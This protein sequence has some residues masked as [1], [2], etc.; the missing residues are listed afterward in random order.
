MAVRPVS[1]VSDKATVSGSFGT[2]TGTVTFTFFTASSTCTGTS[3][4]SGTVT[5]DA[6]G[7]AHPSASQGPLSAGSYS[8]IAHYN[9]DPNYTATASLCTPLALTARTPSS[10]TEIHNASHTVVTSWPAGPTLHDTA[11]LAGAFGTPPAPRT[12]ALFTASSTCTGT[13]VG[14]GTVTLDASGVAHPSASQGPLSAGSYS[15]IAHYNGDPNYTEIGRASCRERVTALA[16]T[17]PNKIH[18]ARPK[19]EVAV[20]AGTTVHYLSTMRR[21]TRSLCDWSSDVCSSDLSTCTGTSVASGTVTLDASGVAHPS[22][23]QG[24]LSAGSYSFIAHYNG[25]PNYT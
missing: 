7:V 11:T 18:K 8:F 4:G 19:A 1:M 22:A 12:S 15:F 14:S 25:D 3:V 6:S 17:A 21:H 5:L 20:P 24:P 2:P 13:S 23:S 16:P 10:A 9:G